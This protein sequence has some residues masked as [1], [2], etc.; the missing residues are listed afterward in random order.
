MS[1]PF[2]LAGCDPTELSER[3][4]QVLRLITSGKSNE[5]IG[6]TLYL[7]INTVKTYIRTSYRK[8]G[9]ATR[10]QAVLWGVHHGLLEGYTLVAT[11]DRTTGDDLSEPFGSSL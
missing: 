3:E 5:E 4:L 7:G 10:T 6:A 8:I 9:V 2:Q 1:T 11:A